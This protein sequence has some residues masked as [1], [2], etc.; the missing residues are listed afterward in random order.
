MIVVDEIDARRAVL[1]LADAIVD[2]LIAI[3]AGPT[4]ATLAVIVA[5]A[6]SARHC[7]DARIQQT[8]VGVWTLIMQQ[9]QPN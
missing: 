7:V 5:D 8:L 3:V 4:N 1:A 2:V 9:T 6:I